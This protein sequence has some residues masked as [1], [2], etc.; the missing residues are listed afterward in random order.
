MSHPYRRKEPIDAAQTQ[1]GISLRTL[2]RL[3]PVLAVFLPPLGTAPCRAMLRDVAAARPRVEALG[4]RVV[5]VHTGGDEAEF[6]RCE[7]QYVAR[8]ADTQAE[9]YEAM[10]L[11]PAPT[12]GPGAWV[13]SLFRPNPPAGPARRPGVFLFIRGEAVKGHVLSTP[14]EPIDYVLMAT[15]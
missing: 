2:S 14:K 3:S 6:A 9:L 5:L 11:D 15:R 12:P 13:R 10:K 7:M 8:I 4:A 1:E